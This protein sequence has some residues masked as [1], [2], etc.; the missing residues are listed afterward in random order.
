M[1]FPNEPLNEKDALFLNLR[2]RSERSAAAVV[3]QTLPT[4]K[5]IEEGALL[6]GWDIVLING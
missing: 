1:F 6:F 5:E 4:S 3:A 2:S